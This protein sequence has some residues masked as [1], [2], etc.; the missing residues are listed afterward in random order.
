M[1]LQLLFSRKNENFQ[2]MGPI[3][4]ERKGSTLKGADIMVMKNLVMWFTGFHCIRC[5]NRDA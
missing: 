5:R 1:C 3:V 2:N 4:S